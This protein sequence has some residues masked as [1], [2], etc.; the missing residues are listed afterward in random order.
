MNP[1]NPETK[2]LAPIHDFGNKLLQPSLIESLKEYVRWQA[3][4]RRVGDPEKVLDD[5][6]T[7]APV[8]I[9][10]DLTTACN[11]AC[12]HCVDMD[13]LNM[14]IK[15]EY[16]KL[17]SSLVELC[18]RG[19][20]SAILI[21]GGEPTVF[22]KFPEVVSLLKDHD[23]SVAVVSNGS[24]MK[25]VAECADRFDKSDWIR[26][27]LDSG[28]DETFQAMHKP[29]KKLTLESIC[30]DVAEVKKDFP[31]LRIGFSFIVTW[32]GAFT[33]DA[34]IV[35]N[36][37][38]IAAAAK[39][40][41]DH[42]F[43]YISVKP[44]LVRS[45]DN[46]AEIVGVNDSWA[47]FDGIIE[48][49]KAGVQDAKQYETETFKVVESTNLR[50]LENKSYANYTRQPKVCHMTYFRQV[51]SP[52]GLF[53]CPV[54]RHVEHAKLGDKHAYASSEAVE[55][56]KKS[57][58]RQVFDFD[59]S[60]ECKEVTCLYNSANWMIED[61]IDNPEKLENLEASPEREDYFL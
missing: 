7:R 22:P 36:I 8:S 46:N 47:D 26:L 56:T 39:L 4:V 60:C 21:G 43:D 2:E 24:G 37:H 31:G 13:I 42:R 23:V 55:E 29:K 58:V 9:N 35:E 59:A 53:N 57:T 44:F 27:S 11:Y 61:L 49:I 50:V 34:A 41:R 40:A 52:L 18:E 45:P 10:L 6:P 5:Y 54:Y 16:E 15:Y 38:E 1:A 25:R 19:L 30:E 20:K 33:N 14:G 48:R 12:D 17:M 3:E 28:S 51:L 32:K